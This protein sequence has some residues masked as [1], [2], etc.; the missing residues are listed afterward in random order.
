MEGFELF[1]KSKGIELLTD[2]ELHL[3]FSKLTRVRFTK[4]ERIVK[5]GEFVKYIVFIENGYVKV[6]SE[7][8]GKGVILNIYGPNTYAGIAVMVG[9]EKHEFDITALEDTSAILIDINVIQSFIEGNG[10]FAQYMISTMGD[11]LV[12]YISHNL[13]TLNQNHIHG[14][15]ANTLLYLSQSVFKSHH[16]DLLL[17]RKELSQFSNISRENVIKVLY[18][19]NKEGLIKLSGKHIHILNHEQLSRLA[20]IC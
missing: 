4:N 17:S 8:K 7:S 3:L 20:A 1:R 16:F 6:H 15:L 9:R 10:L 14:R 18:E 13:I 19:F 2:D 11:I 12:H 5:S